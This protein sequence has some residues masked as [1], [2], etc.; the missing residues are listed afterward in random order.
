MFIGS[1]E[2]NAIMINFDNTVGAIGFTSVI[3]PQWIIELILPNA[4]VKVDNVT[5]ELIRDP[6]TGMSKITA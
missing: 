4:I 1:T 5:G 6:I 3:V 2:G